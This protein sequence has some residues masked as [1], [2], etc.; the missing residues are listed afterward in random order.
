MTIT[1]RPATVTVAIPLRAQP[2]LRTMRGWW[3][4]PVRRLALHWLVLGL[5]LDPLGKATKRAKVDL[6]TMTVKYTL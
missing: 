5:N 1:H 4:W 6:A 3:W 2:A